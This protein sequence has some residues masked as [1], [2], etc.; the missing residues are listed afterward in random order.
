MS[1]PRRPV[2]A[3]APVA[4]PP[5]PAPVSPALSPSPVGSIS[6]LLSAYSNH[7]AETTPRSSTN[8]DLKSPVAVTTP[9]TSVSDRNAPKHEPNGLRTPADDHELPP[10]PP[11][12]KDIHRPNT[13]PVSRKPQPQA[14]QSPVD[15]QSPSAAVNSSPQDQLWRRRSVRSEK[16][17]A[18]PE[19]KLA[20]SHGST[21]TS[22]A[23]SSQGGMGG[24][25]PHSHP[26]GSQGQSGPVASPAGT[27]VPPPRTPNAAFP[28]RNIRPAASL[29]QITTHDTHMG[30]KTSSLAKEPTAK[31]RNDGEAATA[32]ARDATQVAPSPVPTVSPMKSMPNISSPQSIVRL[33]TPE[34][35]SSDVKHPILE[36][37]VSPVSPAS[38]PDL[39]TEAKSAAVPNGNTNGNPTA[40]GE[41]HVR[42]AKSSPS[43]APKSGTPTFAGH[44]PMGL[45]ASP[46]ASRTPSQTQFPARTSSKTGDQYRPYVA[47]GRRDPTGPSTKLPVPQQREHQYRQPATV[48]AVS[49]NGSVA[50]DE[51]VRPRPPVFD[52][53]DDYSDAPEPSLETAE[54]EESDM[55]DHPGAA[56]FP[57]NWYKPAPAE[58]IMDA[59][60]LESKH[61]R[62]LT[63][64]RYM[65]AARQRVNPIACRTCG[66]KDRN[67]D[68]YICS[69]CHLNICAGCSGSLRRLRGN[70]EQLLEKLQAKNSEDT[71]SAADGAVG[72]ARPDSETFTI[73]PT[74][75]PLSFV[76]EAQ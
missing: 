37:V 38:S 69:A 66:Y 67:A 47:A 6:S 10:P 59:R 65:T 51:T 25:S 13:P 27:R 75:P 57:R 60:P 32:T 20:T 19:L 21:A 64:H 74:D 68:C 31:G 48:R 1:I 36:T 3:P 22:V 16:N 54:A 71:Q 40:E 8:S 39:P 76:I 62:C 53:I 7:S 55:T 70:L 49:E 29:Q 33:P 72:T 42:H 45:P 56:L 46:A 23:N 2:A 50:S 24:P 11:P 44:P 73:P 4:V 5:A 43:L 17:L 61:F 18:V 34:Y 63:S 15:T 52:I 9:L 30:Q 35:E 14:S 26:V 28:G 41:T 12:L 58:E